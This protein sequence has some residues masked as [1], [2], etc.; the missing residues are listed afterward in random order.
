MACATDGAGEAASALLATAS[1]SAAELCRALQL[2][3]D[4]GA[5]ELAGFSRSFGPRRLLKLLSK[6]V[7]DG[8]ELL[9][10]LA[11]SVI[12][13]CSAADGGDGPAATVGFAVA[14]DYGELHQES[15]YPDQRVALTRPLVGQNT[16]MPGVSEEPVRLWLSATAADA[17]A[18]DGCGVSFVPSLATVVAPAVGASAMDGALAAAN[19]SST[20]DAADGAVLLKTP[21][22]RV[23]FGA[24]RRQSSTVAWRRVGHRA[25]LSSRPHASQARRS[26]AR[27]GRRLY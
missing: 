7:P 10:E 25:H 1:A 24:R 12:T 23:C 27:Y 4:G 3:L 16:P 6:G 2:V 18:A 14:Q 11:D 20:T 22:R 21:S 13:A 9:E 15:M 17:A 5:P 26:S 8:D 19:A